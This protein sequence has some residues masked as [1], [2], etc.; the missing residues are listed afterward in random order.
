[1][2]S[3]AQTATASLACVTFTLSACAGSRQVLQE[4]TVS[5][6][7]PGTQVIV[8]GKARTERPVHVSREVR[9]YEGNHDKAIGPKVVVAVG[10]VPALI[11]LLMLSASSDEPCCTDKYES[12]KHVNNMGAAL[13]FGGLAVMMAGIAYNSSGNGK[14]TANADAM[15]IVARRPDGSTRKLVVPG[16]YEAENTYDFTEPLILDADQTPQESDEAAPK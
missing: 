4:I 5:A 1:M 13:A 9:I 16:G 2:Y 10:L 12:D 11:G 14:W 7:T 8:E 15:N 6:N 3:M